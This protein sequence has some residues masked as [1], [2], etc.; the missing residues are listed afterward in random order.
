MGRRRVSGRK[1]LVVLA[2]THP[3]RKFQKKSSL[4][5]QILKPGWELIKRARHL[6][7]RLDKPR[8]NRRI[9]M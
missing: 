8:P 7:T 5:Y 2:Q 9:S 6:E 1:P 4:A 3:A